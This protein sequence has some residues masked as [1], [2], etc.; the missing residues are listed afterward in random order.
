MQVSDKN[1][2]VKRVSGEMT[3]CFKI[4]SRKRTASGVSLQ[5]VLSSSR[6]QR[7]KSAEESG[8]MFMRPAKSPSSSSRKTVVARQVVCP[9]T[10]TRTEEVPGAAQDII[11]MTLN[12]VRLTSSLA[13]LSLTLRGRGTSRA[14]RSEVACPAGGGAV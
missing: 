7:W 12:V 1:S 3:G 4:A 2:D 13:T 11:I 5:S 10:R 14:A 6:V 8:G 9:L